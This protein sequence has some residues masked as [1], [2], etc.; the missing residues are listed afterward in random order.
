MTPPQLCWAVRTRRNKVPSDNRWPMRS[1]FIS[2]V[3]LKVDYRSGFSVL[4]WPIVF[5]LIYSLPTF[6]RQA[7]TSDRSW[8]SI[9]WEI[10]TTGSTRVVSPVP[11]IKIL[12]I[13]TWAWSPIQ[14]E[15]VACSHRWTNSFSLIRCDS[16]T[17]NILQCNGQLHYCPS[18]WISDWQ[19]FGRTEFCL[20]SGRSCHLRRNECHHVLFTCRRPSWH[21]KTLDV[22]QSHRYHRWLVWSRVIQY[23][24]RMNRDR[25]PGFHLDQRTLGWFS[26]DTWTLRMQSAPLLKSCS[27][28]QHGFNFTV[29]TL[30]RWRQIT[31]RIIVLMWYSM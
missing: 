3:S 11:R 21:G 5:P 7:P 1:K 10:N 26:M 4:R 12:L 22:C 13:W 6:S 15:P 19:S 8:Q 28:C 25:S 27:I 17:T 30:Q 9:L 20:Q 16:D 31:P 24:V 18:H 14:V 23:T 2:R 29:I